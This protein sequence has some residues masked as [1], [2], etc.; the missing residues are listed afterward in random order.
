MKKRPVIWYV[1]DLPENL[2]RF[3][4]NHGDTFIVR[5]FSRPDDVLDALTSGSKPDALLCD[6]FF[7]ETIETAK[8][9]EDRVGTKA[10]ELRQFGESIGANRV[11]Y[12]AGIKLI[13]TV[14]ERFGARFPIYAYTSKGPYL[15]ADIGFDRIGATGARWLFKGKFGPHTERLILRQDI[16]ESRVRNSFTMRAARFFWVSLFGSG[17]L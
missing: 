12:Q 9:M 1:D 7:Y 8:E 2:E 16:E 5:T 4:Q 10:A 13:E 11:D 6:I 14:S 17:I 15:L 3:E